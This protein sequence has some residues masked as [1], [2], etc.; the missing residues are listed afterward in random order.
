[1]QMAEDIIRNCL[2][3][4]TSMISMQID[5]VMVSTSSVTAAKRMMLQLNKVCK[6]T[7]AFQKEQE[8]ITRAKAI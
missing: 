1:M 5:F 7:A 8:T 2:Y 4:L 3:N 6:R